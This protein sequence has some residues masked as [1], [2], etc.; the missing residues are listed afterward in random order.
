M[1]STKGKLGGVEHEFPLL[2]AEDLVDIM[3]TIPNPAGSILDLAAL[4]KWSKHPH[5][6][7]VFLHV[8]AKKLNTNLKPEEVMKWGSIMG[9][10]NAA[11][12]LF[13]DSIV[14]GED[15]DPNPVPPATAAQ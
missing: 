3:R 5:G 7:V 2:T 8:S 6:S 14:F 15:P 4:D 9:R 13:Q 11:S 1:A 10:A 12:A